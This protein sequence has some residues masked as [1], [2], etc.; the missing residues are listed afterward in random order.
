MTFTATGTGGSG[1][2]TYLWYL[3][4]TPTGITSQTFTPTLTGNASIYCAVTSASCGPVNTTT[5]NI[6]VYGN[7]SASISGGASPICNNTAP[8]TYTVTGSG[9]TGTYTYLWY[10]NGAS[11]G[12]TTK[13]Y[14]PGNLNAN[15]TI[16][17]AV[18][19]GSCGTVN[20]PV[21]TITVGGNLSAT[22]SGGISPV[23]YSTSPGT[24]TAT[25]TGGTGFYTYLWYLNGTSTGI[26]TQTY[27]PTLT[28]NAAIR[29]AVTS[30]T[31]G[32][33]NTPT[34]N[35]TVFGQLNATIGGG[36]NP[37]CY[38]TPAGNFN[39][40]VTGGNGPN[41]FL[42]YE[43]GTGTGITTPNYNPGPLTANTTIYCKV[44]NTSCGVVNTATTTISVDGKVGATISGGTSPV[45]YNSAPGILTAS[46]SGG[47]GL[48]TYL[49][50]KN[51]A[52]TGITTQ[53]YSPGNLTA[54][55]TIYCAVTS[56]SCGTANSNN[57]TITVDG[58]LSATLGGGTNP[59]C[60]NTS[61]GTFTV[62]GTGGTGVYSYLWY[63]NSTS[64]GATTQT[65][66][67]GVLAANTTLYCAVTSGSCGTVN[68]PSA[69]ITIQT[70]P[71]AP[72]F[73]G[74]ADDN[75]TLGVCSGST[76]EYQINEVANA[77]TYTW[78][79]PAG[80]IISDGLGHTGN[81]LTFDGIND[82]GEYEVDITFPSNF[83]SGNV[84]VYASNACGNGPTSTLA[85]QS[86]P[87]APGNINGP[88]TNLCHAANQIYNITTAPGGYP[89][90]P[91][92]YTWT[93]PNGA[94]ISPGSSGNSITVS[95][96]P[97]FT[98]LGYIT[99]KA[100][101]GCGTSPIDSLPVSAFPLQPGAIT[102]LTAVC[103]T[104]T[105][106]VYST[107]AV[108]G[109]TSYTW[110]IS[111]G[112]SFVGSTT[113]TS[114]TVTYANA[115]SATVNISVKANNGCGSSALAVIAAS[116]TS[117]CTTKEDENEGPST[118]D[119]RNTPSSDSTAISVHELKA[120][121][122]PTSGI[123]EVVF[124]ALADQKFSFVVV[125]VLGNSVFKETYTS[126][127]G[128]NLKEF[129]FSR[130]PRGIY[131]ITVASDEAET[132]TLRIVL[133]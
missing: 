112:A 98:G 97:A 14:S 79:G 56:G 120:Y 92:S 84:S 76:H 93:V 17:C 32:I 100:T 75:Y 78:T 66:N 129:D 68:T 30:A 50:Y 121:P 91:T 60:N 88:A 51:N 71:I 83:I 8:G 11:T 19:S 47:T 9:G 6:I 104:Q 57:T 29:C 35:I 124:D 126:F 25:G 21:T 90:G 73:N 82:E 119:S 40:N 101:N 70:S 58:N 12:I 130:L 67:P 107:A 72:V 127:K 46:G 102:G 85:V 94:S 122:N 2:Y 118:S 111:G 13:T 63:K 117:T 133:Q 115:T 132:K 87:S 18:T 49:W 99:V 33:T 81:P 69:S 65:Y 37:I 27:S 22:I 43:N 26:T 3:N 55:T 74:D 105:A 52:N 31:C 20:S 4:G 108:P 38:N 110:S 62:T 96:G 24:F 106:D 59:I 48:Y 44:T 128:D 45:C 109:A 16:Y 15:T 64:T 61:P 7:L 103:K 36:N 123:L 41:N 10:K 34:T 80:C 54:N 42:W 125:D 86:R 23:C 39:V 53:T 89:D 131:F 114:V 77:T 113:G 95:Y 28:A 5:T 1:S 116:V